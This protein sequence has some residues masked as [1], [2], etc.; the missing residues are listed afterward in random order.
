[1]KEEKVISADVICYK[2]TYTLWGRIYE[3]EMDIAI[4]DYKDKTTEARLKNDFEEAIY[5]M[6]SE[7][8]AEEVPKEVQN[9]IKIDSYIRITNKGE[10]LQ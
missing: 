10:A 8:I 3:Q 2:V 7:Y 5:V 4:S 9:P 6:N 1:M